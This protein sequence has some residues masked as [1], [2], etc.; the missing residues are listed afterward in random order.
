MWPCGIVHGMS[1]IPSSLYLTKHADSSFHRNILPRR[2]LHLPFRGHRN[3]LL[4]GSRTL[5]IQPLRADRCG[6]EEY[7][8]DC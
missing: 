2:Y 8:V 4:S 6:S 7:E 1:H 5:F 3:T